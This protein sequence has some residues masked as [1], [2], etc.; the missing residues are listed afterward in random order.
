MTHAQPTQKGNIFPRCQLVNRIKHDLLFRD[1]PPFS[2]PSK[3][4]II[5]LST[6]TNLKIIEKK[7]DLW[8]KKLKADLTHKFFF[9]IFNAETTLRMFFK[10]KKIFFWKKFFQIFFW[11][12]F[13]IYLRSAFFLFDFRRLL[14][15]TFHEI[16][17]KRSVKIFSDLFIFDKS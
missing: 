4:L 11:N 13:E 17:P 12:F 5:L 7:A 16:S 15:K 9:R 1:F 6:G 10:T 3:P 2:K 14:S 8:G